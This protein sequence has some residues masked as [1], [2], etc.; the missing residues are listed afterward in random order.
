MNQT[1]TI[2][3]SIMNKEFTFKL[4]TPQGERNFILHQGDSMLFVGA[5]G[6]GKTRLAVEI[7]NQLGLH[8]Q[9]I[10]AH[11]ALN[12][13]PSVTQIGE[14][15][16]RN[17]LRTGHT[18]VSNIHLRLGH[19]Y[20]G[21]AAICLL[22][23]FEQLIQT[24]YAEQANTKNSAY[25]KAKKNDGYFDFKEEPLLDK[26]KV[27]WER[28]L[29]HRKLAITA[30]DIKVIPSDERPLSA[31]YSA[32]EMSDGERA[33]FY[34]IGHVL[35]SDGDS[36]L[37]IDEPE[38]HIHKS[39][40]LSLWDELEAIRPDCSFIF[41]SHDLEFIASRIGQKFVITRYSHTN[42]WTVEDVP[43]ETGFSEET[44]TSIMGSRKPILFVE[45]A[46]DGLD[47]AVYR[48]CFPEY[49][50]MTK[51]SCQEVIHAVTTFRNNP[52]LTRITCSGIVDAD[53]R[54]SD[55]IAYL[56]KLGIG[57]L[58]VSEIE[59]IFL[60]PEV[61]R[62]IGQHES[63]MEPDLTEK[64]NIM[65]DSIIAH[66]NKGENLE[67]T[68]ANYCRRQ[69]DQKLKRI[70]LSGER[71]VAKITTLYAEV[72]KQL[73]INDLAQNHK[74]KIEKYVND[75]NIPGLLSVYDNKGLLAEICTIKS[76]KLDAFKAWV[77]RVL[78][79]KK[80]TTIINE[81]KKKLPIIKFTP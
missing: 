28:L 29:P 43:E 20:Q 13:N 81:I 52:S 11:R 54:S 69:I 71:T 18:E 70:D 24:L 78:R 32:S 66:I 53:S 31:P 2:D 6:G 4:S 1:S 35:C 50:V 68:I 17:K 5:N 27:I 49:T 77:V 37:I 9:R 58:P 59:N 61:A 57:V 14:E 41:I 40:M 44:V 65:N 42:E 74:Q 73:D 34:L 25:D 62:A 38:L 76:C 51:G 10:S 26:L 79:D 48:A 67:Q 55:E 33:I 7:E 75:K 8:S 21:N 63:L 3:S 19:R 15:K 39:I 46:E 80:Q 64:I 23:D 72:T 56:D 12:L 47:A 36:V 16:A 22:N 60:L 30:D 45:G